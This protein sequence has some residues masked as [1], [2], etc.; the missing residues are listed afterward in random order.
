MTADKTEAKKST[1]DK[2]LAAATKAAKPGVKP[3]SKKAGAKPKPA[4]KKTEK[5][6]KVKVVHDSFSIP[7]TEHRKITEIKEACLKA[8]LQ[9]K[10]SEVLRAGLKALG[11]M[12]GAQLKGAMAGLGKVKTAH[13]KKQ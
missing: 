6:P 12:N 2:A 9:V 7:K 3:A 10:K 1:T 5:A 4:A 8:G 11:E 13:S